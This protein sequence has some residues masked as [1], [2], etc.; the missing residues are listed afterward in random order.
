MNISG[1]DKNKLI[2]LIGNII[3]KLEKNN[4]LDDRRYSMAKI[5]SF[6]RQLNQKFL[7]IIT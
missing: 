4:F 2:N 6:S 3:E 7:F 1:I 5:L